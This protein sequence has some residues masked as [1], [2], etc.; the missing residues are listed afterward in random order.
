[1]HWSTRAPPAQRANCPQLARAAQLANT[2][3]YGTDHEFDAFGGGGA[4]AAEGHPATEGTADDV[5]A[6]FSGDPAMKGM[7]IGQHTPQGYQVTDSAGK[8][9]GYYH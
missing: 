3:K 5:T 1:M 6:R 2:R 8:L 4:N 7:R 9:V